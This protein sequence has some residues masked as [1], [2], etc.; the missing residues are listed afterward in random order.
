MC[1]FGSKNEGTKKICTQR[2]RNFKVLRPVFFFNIDIHG[3]KIYF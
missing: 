2:E 1:I 3:F